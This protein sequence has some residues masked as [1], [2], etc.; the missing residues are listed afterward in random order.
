MSSPRMQVAIQNQQSQFLQPTRS[1][2]PDAVSNFK[3][4]IEQIEE[5]DKKQIKKNLPLKSDSRRKTQKEYS[6]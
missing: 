3:E 4:I 1:P 6:K 5:K 2:R